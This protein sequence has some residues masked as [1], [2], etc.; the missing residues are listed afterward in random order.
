MPL[1]FA[2]GNYE[3]VKLL[4][5]HGASVEVRSQTGSGVLHMAAAA[6]KHE[7]CR[8]LVEAKPD[9]DIWA[10]DETGKNCA[11]AVIV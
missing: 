8:L 7:I 5:A 2:S 1:I 11:R 9:I 4:L 10:H 3:I 6:G